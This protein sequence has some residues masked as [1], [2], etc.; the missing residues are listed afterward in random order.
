M[1]NT[2]VLIIGIGCLALS[3]C[4]APWVESPML[5]SDARIRSSDDIEA[6]LDMMQQYEHAVESMDLETVRRMVSADYY[7]NAGTTDVTADDYGFS[8]VLPM[9]ES[10]REHVEEARIDVEVHEIVIAEDRAEVLFD[11]GITMLYRV[12]ENAR[13]ETNR[14]VARFQL[15]REETGWMIVSGL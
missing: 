7:E 5:A 8:G 9:L 10:V 14:D 4:G 3:A 2:G 1:R 13:W 12:G 15:Q 6:I 11:F